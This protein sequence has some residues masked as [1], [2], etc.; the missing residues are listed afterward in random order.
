LSLFRISVGGGWQPMERIP[1]PSRALALM[2][3]SAWR[4]LWHA[5]VRS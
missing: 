5:L 1:V 2:V 4:G 3:V